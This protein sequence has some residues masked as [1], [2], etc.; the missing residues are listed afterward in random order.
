MVLG[1][2][3]IMLETRK[4]SLATLRGAIIEVS[5]IWLRLFRQEHFSERLTIAASDHSSQLLKNAIPRSWSTWLQIRARMNSPRGR[6]R[7]L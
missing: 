2:R 1:Q 4:A 5:D 3:S 6:L 7:Q